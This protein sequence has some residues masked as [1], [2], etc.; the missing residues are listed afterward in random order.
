MPS[1]SDKAIKEFT[2]RFFKEILGLSDDTSD[3]IMKIIREKG[4]LNTVRQHVRGLSGEVFTRIHKDI[5]RAE[6]D[7]DEKEELKSDTGEHKEKEE[8]KESIISGSFLQYFLS[9][10]MD[11]SVTM[12]VKPEDLRDP[13]KRRMAKIAQRKQKNKSIRIRAIRNKIQELRQQMNDIRM[14]KDENNMEPK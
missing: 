12:D 9:E 5:A 10:E 4:E 11:N 2:K 7:D 8:M 14:G 13:E 6:K 1:R 3:R